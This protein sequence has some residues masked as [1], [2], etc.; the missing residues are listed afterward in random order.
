MFHVRYYRNVA[1]APPA[2]FHFAH[3][4]LP[5]PCHKAVSIGR[6]ELDELLR[7]TDLPAQIRQPLP[8]VF[9]VWLIITGYVDDC[10]PLAE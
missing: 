3:G 5:I 2:L 1:H 6:R 10:P 4:S 7:R 8:A 9:V